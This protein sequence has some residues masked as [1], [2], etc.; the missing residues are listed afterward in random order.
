MRLYLGV[1]ECDNTPKYLGIPFCKMKSK[2]K[3]FVELSDKLKERLARGKLRNLSQAGMATLIRSVAQA[4]PTYAMPT[5]LLPTSIID[6]LD[7]YMRD[8]FWGKKR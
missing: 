6:K 8:F 1:Q 3:Y 4:L 5:V 2:S 7:R